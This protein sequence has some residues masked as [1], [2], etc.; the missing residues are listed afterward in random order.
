MKV[1]VDA[2]A[3]AAIIGREPEA[4]TL[5]DV[6]G[7]TSARLTS[8]IAIWEA[9]RAV[10]WIRGVDVG[11]A[12]ALVLDFLRD[13]RIDTVA[14]EPADAEG[15]VDAHVRFGKGVN[16]AALNM[17][18]CF[19]YA[20]TRRHADMILFKGGDFALTDLKDATLG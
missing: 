20:A 10:E 13:A 16:A 14:V 2:S 9:V 4:T 17:G 3:I 6:L 18:D 8:P 7:I 11:E 19:A 5:A 12:H 15:A 1:F